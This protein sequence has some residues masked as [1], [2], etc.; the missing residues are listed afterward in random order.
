M[1]AVVEAHTPADLERA[2]GAGARIVGVN[3]RDLEWLEV[4]LD[5]ALALAGSVP[6]GRVVVV[7]SGLRSREDVL[8]AERAGA[9]AVLVGE[10]LM[11]SADPAAAVRELLGR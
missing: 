4:D 6:P 9:H 2:L 11:R 7:E 1:S 10:A 3:A 8:R 5:A